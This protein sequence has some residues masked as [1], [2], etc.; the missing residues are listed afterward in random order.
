M[1]SSCTRSDSRRRLPFVLGLLSA[2]LFTSP[3]LGE[4]DL[5][6]WVDGVRDLPFQSAA[7]L[8]MSDDGRHLYAA[9]NS[10]LAVLVRDAGSGTLQLLENHHE[11]SRGVRG[12]RC[13]GA[14]VVS[15]D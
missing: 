11:G 4:S 10:A 13:V 1:I 14:L 3:S 6:T 5:L 15:P 12:L 9:G 7:A 2:L 8:A